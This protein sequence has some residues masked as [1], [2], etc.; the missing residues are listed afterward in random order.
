MSKGL[1]VILALSVLF[2][3]CATIKPP[4]DLWIGKDKV[5]HFCVSALVAGTATAVARNQGLDNTE[6]RQKA[7]YIASSIGAGKEAYDKYLKKTFWS[8][9]DLV[10]DFL[11]YLGGY[12]IVKESK[13]T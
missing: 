3:G 2:T 8:W 9:K 7:L 5:Y 6:S 13:K 10:W 1:P 4:R 11:G 12:Y